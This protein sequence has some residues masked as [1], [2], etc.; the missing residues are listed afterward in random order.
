VT[1]GSW[2]LDLVLPL[3]ILDHSRGILQKGFVSENPFG[4][5]A[6]LPWGAVFL[7]IFFRKFSSLVPGV[8]FFI[9]MPALQ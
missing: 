4:S 7:S 9:L 6:L 2:K 1:S 8:I 5:I 3:T